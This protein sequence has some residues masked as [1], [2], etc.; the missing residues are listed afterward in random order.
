MASILLEPSAHFCFVPMES[1]RLPSD[2]RQELSYCLILDHSCSCSV[3]NTWSS[4]NS[5]SMSS[6]LLSQGFGT[7]C[8]LHSEC[9]PPHSSPANSSFSF[10]SG[11]EAASSEHFLTTTP[12]YLNL[13][14]LYLLPTT[15]C[16]FS[17]QLSAQC[18]LSN[19]LC[20]YLLDVYLCPPHLPRNWVQEP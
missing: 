8:P 15:G 1:N 20:D 13:I 11:W 5:F 17:A 12:P 18:V 10:S 6:S 3:H 14:L 19:Y 9:S 4:F 2:K 7:C 16:A